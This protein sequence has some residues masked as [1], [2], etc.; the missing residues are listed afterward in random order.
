MREATADASRAA[1]FKERRKQLMERQKP[2][3]APDR[4]LPLPPPRSLG[5]GDRK[6]T[7]PSYTHP[8][9]AAG[10]AGARWAG[11]HWEW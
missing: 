8:W 10:Q 7:A 9:Q 2:P 6:P 1:S 11:S 3:P 5:A 4:S